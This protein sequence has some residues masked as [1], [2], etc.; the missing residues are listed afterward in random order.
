MN[1]TIVGLGYVG[2]VS[3]GCLASR[4]HFVWGVDINPAKV[5]SLGRG[6]APIVEPG[7]QELL[8]RAHA[9]GRLHATCRMEEALRHSSLCLVSVSTPSRKNGQIDPDH[10]LNACEQIA[11]ALRYLDRRQI[12]V[13]RSSVLPSVFEKIQAIFSHE[14]YGLVDLCVNPEFLREGTAI[15]DYKN[16]PFTIVGTDSSEVECA[17]RELY[18]DLDAPVFVLKTKEATLVKYASN[19]YHALKVA[20]ANEIGALCLA[21]GVDGQAVMEVFCRDTKLNVSPRYLRPGFAFGGSCLPK[22]VRA[23][24]YAA[25]TFD[26]DLPLLEGLLES[27]ARVIDRAFQEVIEFGVRRVG[28]VGLSFKKNTDDLRESPF[29]SLA[30]RLLGKGIDLRI[31]DPNVSLA[32][33]VGANK[34]FI[35]RTLPHLSRLLVGSLEDI[36][37]FSELVV[38]GHDFD[39]IDIFRADENHCC[40]LDLTGQIKWARRSG[41]EVERFVAAVS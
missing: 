9:D 4:G 23:V 7:L 32:R 1:V 40:V 29:V 25:K 26:L 35:E 28:L 21:S 31:F 36:V 8:A 33:L 5:E 13:I 30:E 10:L 19:A 24:L 16:P 34:E 12:V 41:E 14:A 39:G 37:E 17:L 11:V 2:A 27:N 6:Q 38:I 3:A 22:D 18:S 15:A 20:F